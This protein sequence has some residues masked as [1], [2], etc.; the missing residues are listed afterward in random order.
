MNLIRKTSSGGS[1]SEFQLECGQCVAVLHMLV[2]GLVVL[3]RAV[4]MLTVGGV[5][6]CVDLQY[7]SGQHMRTGDAYAGGMRREQV[8]SRFFHAKLM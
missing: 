4:A 3:G 5:G 8:P 2:C 7:A 1:I 6:Y